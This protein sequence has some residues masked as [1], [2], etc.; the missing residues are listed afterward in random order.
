MIRAPLSST[1]TAPSP[2]T[3]SETRGCWPLAPEPRYMTVGWNCTNSMSATT[4]PARSPSPI[5]SPVAT[6]GFVDAVKT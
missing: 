3:A 2:L 5:P 1:R 4:A 6:V